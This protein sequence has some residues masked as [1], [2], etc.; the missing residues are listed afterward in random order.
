MTSVHTELFSSLSLSLSLFKTRL[1]NLPNQLLTICQQMLKTWYIY[2]YLCLP[3]YE[4]TWCFYSI[5]LV[6]QFG[7]LNW[8]KEQSTSIRYLWAYL[9]TQ[10]LVTS[11]QLFCVEII[12]LFTLDLLWLSLL[13][14]IH[15]LDKSMLGWNGKQSYKWFPA[16]TL[17][18]NLIF[19]NTLL[20]DIVCLCFLST[21]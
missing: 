21:C 7:H 15:A 19:L 5:Q 14:V 9:V 16:Q 2:F 6:L 12:S 11:F 17:A 4:K 1:N 3:C 18:S 13:I 8:P 20:A 10:A